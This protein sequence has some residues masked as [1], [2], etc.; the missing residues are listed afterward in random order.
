MTFILVSLNV[1]HV[2]CLTDK[3]QNNLPLETHWKL[4]KSRQE[5]FQFAVIYSEL[6]FVTICKDNCV[7]LLLVYEN[8]DKQCD[9]HSSVSSW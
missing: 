1:S 7:T 9:L 4:C 8:G 6:L 3:K 5:P 2:V